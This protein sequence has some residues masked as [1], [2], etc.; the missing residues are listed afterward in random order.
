[1]DTRSKIVERLPEG[2][3]IAEGC[4]DPLL[5]SQ[6]RQL[7]EWKR[8][9]PL[10]VVIREPDKPLMSARARA[11]L[12]AGLAMVDFVVIGGDSSGR[13]LEEDRE[14]LLNVIRSKHA[15]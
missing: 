11:E 13:L 15:G 7:A 12:A 6:A 9:R 10:A 5:A 2:C 3:D 14:A 4:F 1:M 8:D